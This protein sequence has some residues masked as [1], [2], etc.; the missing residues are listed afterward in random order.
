MYLAVVA[1]ML[2]AAGKI[3]PIAAGAVA[4]DTLLCP[5]V[6][7][8]ILAAP[9]CAWVLARSTTTKDAARIPASSLVVVTIVTAKA[10]D[11]AVGLAVATVVSHKVGMDAAADT[12]LVFTAKACVGVNNL[13]RLLAL[14]SFGHIGMPSCSSCMNT[15]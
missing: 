3:P 2:A 14:F 11:L 15:S 10:A 9:V 4:G 8:T 13:P 7:V 12:G 5:V 6:C 1:M